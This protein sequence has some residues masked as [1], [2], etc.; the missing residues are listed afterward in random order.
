MLGLTSLLSRSVDIHISNRTRNITLKNSRIFFN[1]GSCSAPPLPEVPPGSGDR[2]RLEGSAP[3]WGVA[4]LLVYEADSFTLAV[5]FSNPIDRLK[6][7][8]ELGLELSLGKAH[9][10]DLEAVYARMA[11][12]AYDSSRR[13]DVK[14]HRVVVADG[15]GTARVSD[16]PV[17]VTA[18]M[19]KASRSHVKVV[20]EEQREGTG[21]EGGIWNPW[22][23]KHV[24]GN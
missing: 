22:P 18:T 12:G 23:G 14:F 17:K 20:L 3:F 21:E 13:P 6:F 4:G 16:G 1:C 10:G 15:Y 7:S 8:T 9:L 11:G 5:H 2:C 24:Q 19:S